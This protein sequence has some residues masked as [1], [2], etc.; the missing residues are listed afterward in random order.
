MTPNL[1][2]NKKVSKMLLKSH[3]KDEEKVSLS[4]LE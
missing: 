4:H 3:I 1:R 2:F